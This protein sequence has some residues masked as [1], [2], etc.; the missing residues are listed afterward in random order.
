MIGRANRTVDHEVLN[1]EGGGRQG[2]EGDTGR[3]E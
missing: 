3:D 2:R 1:G